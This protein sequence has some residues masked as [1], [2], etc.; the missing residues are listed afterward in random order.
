VSVLRIAAPHEHLHPGFFFGSRQHEGDLDW[1]DGDPV[2]GTLA[3]AAANGPTIVVVHL[4]RAAV[5]T[6][7][8]PH[9]TAL[10]AE[11][12]ISD[13]AL[14]DVLLGEAA[15]GG[16]LP[17]QLSRSMEAAL[18]RQC[19]VPGGD[20]DPQFPLGFSAALRGS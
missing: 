18:A 5:L 1:K 19:D 16:V 2:L 4:D 8:V 14:L 11:F 13:D 15:P 17:F 6:Q 3:N 10:Y 12:G 7:L 20:P 9:S